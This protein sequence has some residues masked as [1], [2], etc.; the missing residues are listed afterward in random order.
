MSSNDPFGWDTL[1]IPL[2]VMSGL[3]TAIG[4]VVLS[5][6]IDSDSWGRILLPA[7]LVGLL[8]PLWFVTIPPRERNVRSILV[9]LSLLAALV[10]VYLPVADHDVS[11]L[12]VV[13]GAA[14]VLTI[15]TRRLRRRQPRRRRRGAP[16]R[17]RPTP[18]L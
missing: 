13:L 7:G 6:T 16:V 8:L 17:P 2:A 5:A 12:G 3:G 15:Y 1:K 11:G 10:A 14:T 9:A 4:V 18:M